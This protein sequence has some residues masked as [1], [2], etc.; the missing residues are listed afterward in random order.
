MINFIICD[1]E[2]AITEMVKNIITKVVFKTSLDYKIHIFNSYNKEFYNIID[3]DLPNKIYVLDIE[4]KDKSGLEIAKY[5]REK[6]WDSVI[7]ILTAHYE[8][9]SLAYKS[10]ILLF[11]FISKFD[12]FD[13]KIDE[14]ILACINKV[15]SQTKLTIKINHTIH[16]LEYK[17]ILY[18]TYD[19]FKRKTIIKTLNKTYEV[20]ETLSSIYK[21]LKGNFIY[22]HRACIVNM[23]NVIKIDA[24]NKLIK[25]KNDNSINLLSRT[26]LK[27][28]KNYATS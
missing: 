26:Y 23:D 15:L 2:I 20:T 9:E 16:K 12:L 27:D 28:V 3:S 6:D 25:F 10:R 24:K 14:S 11:D 5:I 22:T 8:L 4:V 21:K 18:L 19:S 7:L 1:D 13:K 17:D